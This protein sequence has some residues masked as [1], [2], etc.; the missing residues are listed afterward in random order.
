MISNIA[1]ATIT[2]AVE[3]TVVVMAAVTYY[4]NYLKEL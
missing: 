3:V 2:V 1:S 4:L